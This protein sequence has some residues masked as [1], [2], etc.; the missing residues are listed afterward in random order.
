M[1]WSTTCGLSIAWRAWHQP[2]E[3]GGQQGYTCWAHC[4]M[5]WMQADSL[6]CWPGWDAFPPPE[7]SSFG[8]TAV[9]LTSAPLWES[10]RTFQ[11]LKVLG[12][13]FHI[14][15]IPSERKVTVEWCCHL[16][17]SWLCYCQFL[18]WVGSHPNQSYCPPQAPNEY[19]PVRFSWAA[20]GGWE[21]SK[22]WVRALPG[23]WCQ[24]AWRR[25]QPSTEAPLCVK[26]GCCSQNRSLLWSRAPWIVEWLHSHG[27][28]LLMVSARQGGWEIHKERKAEEFSST[29]MQNL[30]TPVGRDLM[31]L[32]PMAKMQ[33]LFNLLKAIS[34]WDCICTFG[35]FPWTSFGLKAN[36]A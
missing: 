30:G 11:L 19:A 35:F 12:C 27:G 32:L 10:G 7:T 29:V 8:T 2:T 16:I 36:P 18:T 5:Y 23:A 1:L 25:L 28:S 14:K 34:W 4:D 3:L 22:L 9:I 13:V 6:N 17:Q 20:S 21:T 26:G 33:W 15:R 31:H 24:S